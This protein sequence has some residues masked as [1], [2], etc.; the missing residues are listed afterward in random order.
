MA[1]V[2]ARVVRKGVLLEPTFSVRAT[3]ARQ[4]RA[5]RCHHPRA[6]YRLDHFAMPPPPHT[7][8]HAEL[9]ADKD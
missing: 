5:C 1:S 4:M 3:S 8:L 6:A 9:V 7:L 2:A